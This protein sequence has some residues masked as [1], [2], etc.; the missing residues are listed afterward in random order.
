MGNSDGKPPD[1]DFPSGGILGLDHGCLQ[2]CLGRDAHRERGNFTAFVNQKFRVL[3]TRIGKMG[4]FRNE[5]RQRTV[6]TRAKPPVLMQQ[7]AREGLGEFVRR[8]GGNRRQLLKNWCRQAP[9]RSQDPWRH[10]IAEGEKGIGADS[11]EY[12]ASQTPRRSRA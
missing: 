9:P 10:A 4:G 12:T 11:W 2:R 1:L 5:R 8:C 3:G 7:E 6:I